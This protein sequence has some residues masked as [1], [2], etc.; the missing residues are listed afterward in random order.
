MLFLVSAYGVKP[1]PP[2]RSA[3]ETDLETA[4]VAPALR[5]LYEFLNILIG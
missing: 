2:E 3:I 1:A 5:V 4:R